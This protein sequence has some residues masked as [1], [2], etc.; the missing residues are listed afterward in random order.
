LYEHE[1]TQSLLWELQ[2]WFSYLDEAHRVVLIDVREAPPPRLTPRYLLD[3]VA[4]YLDAVAELE[5]IVSSA[6]AKEPAEI[7]IRSMSQASPVSVRIDGVVEAIELILDSVIPWRREHAKKMAE[8]AER[9]Q[10]AEIAMYQADA[11]EKRA[12]ARRER[13]EAH[14]AEEDLLGPQ[15]L[16]KLKKMELENEER[17]LE[18][19]RARIN[20]AFEIVDKLEPDAPEERRVS[21]ALR[22]I[23]PLGVL[24]GSPLEVTMPGESMR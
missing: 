16:A 21:I 9:K 6:P 10:E 2:D 18:L 17:R 19:E 20:L 1:W 5:Q 24:T 23:K 13:A 7:W 8:L 22:L 14:Q 12:R 4:P 11:Q 15:R 3:V